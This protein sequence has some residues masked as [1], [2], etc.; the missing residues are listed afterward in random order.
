MS[1]KQEQLINTESITG[2]EIIVEGFVLR[3]TE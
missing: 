3:D 1:W 2:E